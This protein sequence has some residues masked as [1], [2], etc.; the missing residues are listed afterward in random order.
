VKNGQYIYAM[1]GEA[2][3]FWKYDIRN[4]EWDNLED[5]P[6]S[7]GRGAAITY[8]DK[9]D[10]LYALSGNRTP[11]FYRY[12]YKTDQWQTMSPAMLKFVDSHSELIYPGFGNFLYAL[13][14]SS[15]GET[16]E[17]YSYIRYD[18]LSDAWNELAPASFGVDH[19]G[20]MIWPGGEYYYATKGNG[21]LELAM[22]YAF[23]YGS[24]ISGVKP[25]GAHSGWGN[26]SW[27]FNDTQAAEVSFRSGN[28]PD[29]SDAL[30]WDLCGSMQ[31]G[32]SLGSS[33]SA[34]PQDIYII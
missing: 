7:I 28:E 2:V 1:R 32:A 9:G 19:P 6:V 10:Y 31:N 5:L 25:V 27:T 20:S 24:Y 12:N 8:P 4:N 33:S 21:R 18:I 22:Y 3:S 11:N 26:V 30:T 14:G 17:S 29:L 23:C 13:H 16:F 15:W 34:N